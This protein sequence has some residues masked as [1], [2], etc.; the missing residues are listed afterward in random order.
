[1]RKL[2]AI[3]IMLAGGALA[4]STNDR[5]VFYDGATLWSKGGGAYTNIQLSAANFQLPHYCTLYHNGELASATT[6]TVSAAYQVVSNWTVCAT[7]NGMFYDTT[8]GTI[9]AKRTGVYR[10]F[11]QF[12]FL[13]S[14][15][16]DYEI[17]VFTNGF[18]FPCIETKRTMGSTAAFGSCSA[19]G[20]VPL[21]SNDVVT[22]RVIA[23]GANKTF[24]SQHSQF[25]ITEYR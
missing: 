14:P 19:G 21:L 20:L 16:V 4:Q 3:L 7:T 5:P 6:Q 22:I 15:A 25:N 17:A 9:T 24:N 2:I 11:F 8:A 18:E 13:G 10:V 23:D 12:G 1:M